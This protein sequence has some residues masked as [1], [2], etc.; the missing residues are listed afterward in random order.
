MASEEGI[1]ALLNNADHC[2]LVSF[3]AS[4]QMHLNPRYVPFAA[5]P[6]FDPGLLTPKEREPSASDCFERQN[7]SFFSL[8]S[9]FGALKVETVAADDV[10][11]RNSSLPLAFGPNE[12]PISCD[13][14]WML[15]RLRRR[16]AISVGSRVLEAPEELR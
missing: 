8:C 7:I 6:A 13:R 4:E 2:C 16:S 5:Q 12:L 15:D 11:G 14:L 9:F 1:L 3:V 10:C